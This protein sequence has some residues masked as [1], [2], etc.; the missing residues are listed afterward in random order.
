[1]IGVFG[2]TFD[3]PH[4]GHLILAVEAQ[5]QLGLAQVM[6][7]L[8]ADPPHKP[9]APL[10]DVSIRWEML[11]A[12][13]GS[14]PGFELSRVDVDRP[15]PHFAV[16]TLRLL[17]QVRPAER[18]AYLLGGDSL[19]ELLSWHDPAGLVARCDFVAV[20]P[21][22]EAPTDHS[23]VLRQLPELETKLVVLKAPYVA[24]SA[25]DVR[26]RVH[27]GQPYDHLVAPGVAALI[28]THNL[29]R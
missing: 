19:A 11:V 9:H 21:R 4:L 13:V 20:M 5:Q 14:H 16:D 6:W 27:G 24:V 2:G 12:A 15:G 3:P 10:T 17:Q 22:P 29:Y 8:T 18:W 25:S 28:R 26:E 23:G 1:L 7:V